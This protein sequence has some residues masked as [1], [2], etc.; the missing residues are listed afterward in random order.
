ML[1]KW[2]NDHYFI[3]LTS[4]GV[5]SKKEFMLGT[6]WLNYVIDIMTPFMITLLQNKYDQAYSYLAKNKLSFSVPYTVSSVVYF[7]D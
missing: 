1:Q 6:I 7:F 4:E 5:L 2:K 3:I